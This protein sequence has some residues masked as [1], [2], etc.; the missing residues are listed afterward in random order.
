MV[1]TSFKRAYRLYYWDA[2]AF[3]GSDQSLEKGSVRAV[4]IR[5]P[6]EFEDHMY[7]IADRYGCNEWW[8]QV[9]CIELRKTTL[10]ELVHSPNRYLNPEKV[11]HNI[12]KFK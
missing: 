9:W 10:E 12:R 6:L 4:S 2:E 8:E 1:T 5:D 3:D 11:Y 7:E